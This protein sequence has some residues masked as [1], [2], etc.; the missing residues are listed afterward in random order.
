LNFHSGASINAIETV[1]AIAAAMASRGVRPELEIFDMGMAHLAHRLVARG[2]IEPPIYANLML[3][4][5]NSAP[6]DA[7][8]LVALVQALP[9]GTE[10]W[11]AGGFGAY[12]LPAG[13]LAIAMGGHVRTGLEDNPYL[14]AEGTVP[15]TN[16]ALVER[17]VAVAAGLQRPIATPEETRRLLRLASRRDLAARR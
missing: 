8:S 17:A 13:A 10:A 12:Q 7:R 11:A 2:L 3:G 15:A 6:A 14:D 4:F 16:V 1:E 9:A 5:P